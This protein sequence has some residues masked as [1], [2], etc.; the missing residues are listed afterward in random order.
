M[1]RTLCVLH[2]CPNYQ[3]SSLINALQTR[4]SSEENEIDTLSLLE[5][6]SESETLKDNLPNRRRFSF[7][8]TKLLWFLNQQINGSR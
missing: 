6:F 4:S 2:G 7:D 3:S 8:H 1:I 5:Y